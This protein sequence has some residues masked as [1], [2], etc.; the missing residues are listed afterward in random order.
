MGR[1]ALSPLE[2]AEFKRLEGL[3]LQDF[4]MSEEERKHYW[5]LFRKSLRYGAYNA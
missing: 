4:Y 1:D 2:Y 3:R 5:F